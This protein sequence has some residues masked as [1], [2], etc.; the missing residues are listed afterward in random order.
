MSKYKDVVVTLSKKHPETGEPV[1]AGHT[2]V[3]GVLG[4]KKKWYEVES[5]AMNGISEEEMKKELFKLLHPQ[6][7]H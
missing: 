2:Y 5:Q 4:N 1:Q 3:I 6:T 7:H